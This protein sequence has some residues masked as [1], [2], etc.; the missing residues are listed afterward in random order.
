VAAVAVAADEGV[1]PADAG[2]LVTRRAGNNVCCAR[3]THARQCA[4]T[5]DFSAVGVADIA[6]AAICC[7]FLP[8]PR[9]ASGDA[10]RK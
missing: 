4:D 1:L 3:A 8:T 2:S 9:N 10:T 5:D 6:G 7:S